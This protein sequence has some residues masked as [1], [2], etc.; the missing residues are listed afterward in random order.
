MNKKQIH[1]ERPPAEKAYTCDTIADINFAVKKKSG[2]DS[3]AI[4]CVKKAGD[5]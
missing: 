4:A 2:E 5:S 3:A 1:P